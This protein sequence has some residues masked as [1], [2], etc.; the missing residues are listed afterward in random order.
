M[1]SL[2]MRSILNAMYTEN[3]TQFIINESENNYL[4]EIKAEPKEKKM[5]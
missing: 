2:T 1:C 5:R 3:T 4:F